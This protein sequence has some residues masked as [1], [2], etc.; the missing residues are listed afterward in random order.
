MIWKSLAHFYYYS[1]LGHILL[2]PVITLRNKLV[3]QELLLQIRFYR[4]LGHRLNLKTPRTFNEKLQWLKL[5][6]RTPLHVA[7]SDKLLVRDYVLRKVGEAYLIPLIL[8]TTDPKKLVPQN[9]PNYPI[10][11][12]TNHDSGNVVIIKDKNKITWRLLQRNMAKALKGRYNEGKGEWQYQKIK[13]RIVVEKLLLDKDDNIPQ[14]YKLYCFHGKVRFI[15]VH[16]NRFTHHTVDFF[17]PQWQS[18]DCTTLDHS[19]NPIPKP[20]SLQELLHVA[21]KLA[22]DF[23]FVRVDLYAVQNRVYF[24][25]LTF[26]PGS[27]FIK[28][29]PKKWD[30]VFGEMLRL[31]LR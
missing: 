30:L 1:P 7:C 8:E 23:L 21:E 6:Q 2:S 14:D 22:A 29:R 15:E 18:I 5:H 17:D 25:E 3:P 16:A 9:L 19:L 26:Y 24:G 31:P 13:P 27:G 11:V 20:D 4:I 10:I 28:Y 12:K